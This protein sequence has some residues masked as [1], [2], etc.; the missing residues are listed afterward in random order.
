MV[1][2]RLAKR[3]GIIGRIFK[4]LEIGERQYGHHT[5]SK[6][7]KVNNFLWVKTLMMLNYTRPV[8]SRFFGVTISPLN[9]T[10]LFMWCMA[11]GFILSRIKV[12]K[13]RDVLMF[14]K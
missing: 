3:S 12:S 1:N 14:N 11:T 8:F 4:G 7:I 9:Y 5:I 13:F 6:V 2:E 10:G